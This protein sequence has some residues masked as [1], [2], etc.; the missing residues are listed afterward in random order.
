[1]KIPRLMIWLLFIGLAASQA[2][3]A[4]ELPPP[5]AFVG[6]S[7]DFHP[8]KDDG[9][10]RHV[11]DSTVALTLPQVRDIFTAPD[12][13][14]EDHPPMPEVVAHGRKPDLFAC[15]FC[16]R[17]D[18]PGGPENANLTGLPV[19]YTLEQIA[20]FR[21][22]R[23]KTV[24][25]EQIPHALMRKTSIAVTD[26]EASAAAQYFAS[27]TYRSMVDVVEADT[28]PKTVTL[29]WHLGLAPDGG[30]E[31]IGQRIIEIPADSDRFISRD[32]HVRFTAYV[33][34]GSIEKGRL[35]V[36][37][38]G[39]GTTVVC[40]TCHGVDLKGIPPAPPIIGRSPSYMVRQL[41]D[42]QAGNRTGG[43][44]VLMQPTVQN[45][46]L[47]DMIALAAYLASVKP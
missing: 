27:L 13:H 36:T 26:E 35:L 17:A 29:D 47:N 42:F 6:I 39:A 16:H 10:L 45:L 11:P 2:A 46:T 21:D 3:A 23:R 38:G 32:T 19:Q 15:A 37:T 30:T 33:P 40:Q 4:A 34:P 44:N 22:G 18:G 8:E 1:M 24:E 12:W 31:P 9:S 41:F 25:P 28:V 20:A 14:P 7:P 43:P 5:W